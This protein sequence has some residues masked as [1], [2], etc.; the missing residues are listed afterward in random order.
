MTTLI[1]GAS[2]ATGRLLAQELIQQGEQ[3]KIIVRSIESLP[4]QIKQSP[5]VTITE[6]NLLDMTKPQLQ[7]HLH[8]CSSVAS[9]LGH[10]LSFKGIYGQPRRLVTE[11][12][13]RLS[14]CATE[15]ATETPIKF[16]LM[17]TTGNVNQDAGETISIAQTIVLSIIRHLIPPHADNEQA[18]AYLQTHFDNQ[19]QQIEWSIVRP[20]SLI[21]QTHVSEYRLHPSPTRSALFDPGKT[22]RINVAN[23]MS[24][25]ILDEAIW[26]KWKGKMPVI[27]NTE[28]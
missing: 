1:I 3:I 27:Y 10:N 17:N 23:F 14:H 16:V 2:G 13:Q 15:M 12:I 28:R 20:D 21:N 25:L 26:N 6:A 18:A 9:C 8:G 5:L 19:Q 11:A 24:R 4:S 7:A 22:S